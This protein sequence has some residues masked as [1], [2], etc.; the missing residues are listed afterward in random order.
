[1]P[2]DGHRTA[3]AA[4]VARQPGGQAFGGDQQ[5]VDDRRQLVE[6]REGAPH[7]FDGTGAVGRLLGTGEADALVGPLEHGREQILAGGEVPVDGAFG[8][9]GGSSDLGERQVVTGGEQLGDALQ[10]PPAHDGSAGVL[11]G[12]R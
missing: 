11:Q 6:R 9:A 10:H 8:H 5:L 4:V 1:L 3:P 2:G 7:E 12:F